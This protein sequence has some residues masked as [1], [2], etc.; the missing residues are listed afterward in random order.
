MLAYTYEYRQPSSKKVS[1]V[2]AAKASDEL[3]KLDMT[4][5]YL[6]LVVIPGHHIVKMQVE[7]FASQIKNEAVA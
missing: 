3:V 2:A 4:S 5:R 6:G 1:E 7:L